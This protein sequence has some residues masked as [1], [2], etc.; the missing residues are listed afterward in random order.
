MALNTS[1]TRKPSRRVQPAQPITAA[2]Q[3][4]A[5]IPGDGPY[6]VASIKAYPNQAWPSPQPGK[7]PDLVLQ[8]WQAQVL[9]HAWLESPLLIESFQ[10][11]RVQLEFSTSLPRRGEPQ[12]SLE[13]TANLTTD[14]IGFARE[15][16]RMPLSQQF[17]QAITL[18]DTLSEN[19]LPGPQTGRVTRSYLKLQH[20][21]IL[22]AIQELERRF[23]KR[24]DLLD[25][26]A[27]QIA[28]I[29]ALP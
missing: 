20:R 4:R 3:A 8:P 27:A 16:C 1:S 28:K 15:V 21:Q 14:E 22:L 5:L 17:L 19:G 13:L 10:A 7:I 29:D 25:I 24:Q 18:A 9:D 26:L 2:E 6:L 11:G 23:Q 12:L